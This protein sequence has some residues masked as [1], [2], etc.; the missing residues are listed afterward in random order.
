MQTGM[1]SK[2]IILMYIFAV[3]KKKHER[4]NINRVVPSQQQL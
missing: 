2:F 4:V 1:Y 3:E